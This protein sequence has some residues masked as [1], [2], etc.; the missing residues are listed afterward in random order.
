MSTGL[1]DYPP[2]TLF[3]RVV[4]KSRLQAHASPGK[5]VR[6]LLVRQV[7][8]LVWQHKLAPETLRLPG[9]RAVPEVQ[10][11]HLFLKTG[12]LAPELLTYL[13]HAIAFPTVFEVWHDDRVH[14]MAAFKRP[15]EADN[16]KWVV[17]GYFASDWLPGDTVRTPLP[18]VLDLDHLYA[19]ILTAL[20]PFPA[21]PG[22]GLQER[23]DRMEQIRTV[24]RELT[25]CESRLRREKQFNRQVPIH[26]EL[27]RL[28]QVLERLTGLEQT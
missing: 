28:Q 10:V 18:V 5:V 19:H 12:E 9:S 4:P 23:V 7:D 15:S 6:E 2:G 24:Q 8:R 25:R 1:F 13:D 11:F 21:H 22:E 26:A 27:R 20:M 17:S 14:V 16:T 3:G